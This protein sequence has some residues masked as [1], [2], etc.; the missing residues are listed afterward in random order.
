[1]HGLNNLCHHFMCIFEVKFQ[2]KLENLS[3]IGEHEFD[4][5]CPFKRINFINR[6][7]NRRDIVFQNILKYSKINQ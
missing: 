6:S 5:L 1:M 7:S 2:I 4:S 3:H